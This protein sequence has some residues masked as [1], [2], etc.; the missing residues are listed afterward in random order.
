MLYFT[1]V[2]ELINE[3]LN[4]LPLSTEEKIK[5]EQQ[6]GFKSL[7][8]ASEIFYE[9]INPDDFKNIDEVKQ[10]IAKN[11]NYIELVL[12]NGEY[13][14][15]TKFHNNPLRFFMNSDNM[16]QIGDRCF[17]VLEKGI[18]SAS[19]QNQEKLKNID[20]NSFAQFMDDTDFHFSKSAEPSLKS[21]SSVCANG[22]SGV[23]EPF[24]RYR[25]KIKIWPDYFDDYFYGSIAAS[26]YKA[27]CQ[28]KTLGIWW[29]HQTTLYTSV[30]TQMVYWDATINRTRT[31]NTSDNYSSPSLESSVERFS[32]FISWSLT[33]LDP[34]PYFNSYY[35]ICTSDAGVGQLN[36]GLVEIS[37]SN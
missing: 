3:L 17:K 4:V 12:E 20:D 33:G 10:F 5:W 13:S 16:Y 32:G 19:I 8:L 34:N 29:A 37:C 28:I 24:G 7:G 2:N 15:E 21:T 11:S 14:V 9:T 23:S 6:K 30:N 1:D 36:E 25:T 18:V 26:F 27:E 31:V 35:G 22:G